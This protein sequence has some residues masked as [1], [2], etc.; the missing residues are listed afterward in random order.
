[1]AVLIFLGLV[2]GVPNAA[3]AAEFSG[4]FFE[5]GSK[6][7]KLLFTSKS[8]VTTEGATKTQH[9]VF[10]SLEGKALVTEDTVFENGELRQ[11]RVDQLQLGEQGVVEV[12]ADTITFRYTKGGETKTSSEKR[13]PNFVVSGTLDTYV[14]AH[15]AE[16]EKGEKVFVQLAVPERRETIGFKLFK[17]SEA[18]ACATPC[19]VVTMAPSN[20]F[21]SLLVKPL[22][23]VFNADGVGIQEIDGRSSP[24]IKDGSSWA[25]SDVEAVFTAP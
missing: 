16:I 13:A 1:M 12:G 18:L 15:W 25:D 22:R 11:Y 19:V 21:I 5:K 6:R 23:F 14:A 2:A 3:R 8:R 24:K 17:S 4:K 7:T 9:V 20:F 10:S